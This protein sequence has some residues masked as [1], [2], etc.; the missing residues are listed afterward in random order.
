M[1]EPTTD[2]QETSDPL[3]TA[4]TAPRETV[5]RL[6]LSVEVDGV[7]TREVELQ[8]TTGWE[9]DLLKDETGGDK[10]RMERISQ[11]LSQCT[12]RV[13]NRTRTKGIGD[14]HKEDQKFF[15]DVY[16]DMPVPSR[17]FAWVR[18][19]QLSFGHVFK[20]GATCSCKRHN[21]DLKVS[22]L[23]C[24]V[25]EASDE[26]CSE[27]THTYSDFGHMA[28][29]RVPSGKHEYAM[30][31]LRKDNPGDK[32]SAELFPFLVTVDGRKPNSLVDLKSL[33]GEFRDGLRNQFGVGGLDLIVTNVC[34]HC[35]RE[36]QTYL[37]IFSRSFFS[38][39]GK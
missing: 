21:P 37:P 4:L 36:F 34:R 13:G 27:P 18:L 25:Q 23:D 39:G 22:L 26:F 1:D 17:T 6:P 10:A 32:D 3:V 12:V 33:S 11:V 38:R 9:E 15:F 31:K 30:M 14:V 20:F 24:E 35:E 19:R 2:S 29:W 8:R 28:E 7:F 16:Q 5:I